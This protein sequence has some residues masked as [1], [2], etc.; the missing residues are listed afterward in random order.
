MTAGYALLLKGPI[1]RAIG[2]KTMPNSQIKALDDIL[3][4]DNPLHPGFLS[5][6]PYDKGMFL[7]QQQN[8]LKILWPNKENILLGAGTKYPVW[9]NHLP[10]VETVILGVPTGTSALYWVYYGTKE[11]VYGD[12]NDNKTP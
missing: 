2:N 9:H 4:K 12:D 10:S 3:K 6:T 8:I 1:T 7:L 5:M 11:L